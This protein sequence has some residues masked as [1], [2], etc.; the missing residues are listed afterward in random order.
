MKPISELRYCEF[1]GKPELATEK[2]KEMKA[3][4]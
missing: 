4:E 1:A 2:W 3:D